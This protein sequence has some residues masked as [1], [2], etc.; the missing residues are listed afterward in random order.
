MKN[1]NSFPFLALLNGLNYLNL[2][3][4]INDAYLELREQSKDKDGIEQQINTK[5]ESV[6]LD[7]NPADVISV[8]QSMHNYFHI[9]T[10][11]MS[12]DNDASPTYQPTFITEKSYKPITNIEE[13]VNVQI[14]LDMID[15]KLKEKYG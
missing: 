9:V 6:N 8:E 2:D 1:D 15:K 10:E 4:N 14:V 3:K 13:G 11:T 7:I 5:H 12:R